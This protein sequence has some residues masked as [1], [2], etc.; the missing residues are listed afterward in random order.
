ML[1]RLRTVSRGRFWA[2]GYPLNYRTSHRW[3]AG[4]G[5]NIVRCC[6][7]PEAKNSSSLLRL[8]FMNVCFVL[9]NL[10]EIPF[11]LVTRFVAVGLVST[12]KNAFEIGNSAEFEWFAPVMKWNEGYRLLRRWRV[13]AE[14][15]R[16][17]CYGIKTISVFRQV[18]ESS[19]FPFKRRFQVNRI[20]GAR[21]K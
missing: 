12:S 17:F 8:V 7:N 6:P 20:F 18:S 5:N 4:D 9:E 16:K 13:T 1:L 15:C 10:D 21:T 2:R 11:S 14:L 19:L 3:D